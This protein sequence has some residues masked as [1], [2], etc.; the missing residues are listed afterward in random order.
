MRAVATC[1]SMI[2]ELRLLRQQR[3]HRALPRAAATP[4]RPIRLVLSALRRR[5]ARVRTVAHQPRRRPAQPALSATSAARSS[6]ISPPRSPIPPT[7]SDRAR[8]SRPT[9]SAAPSSWT[10]IARARSTGSRESGPTSVVQVKG[11]L[12]EVMTMSKQ[13]FSVAEDEPR[14]AASWCPAAAAPDEVP[15]HA[16][17]RPIPRISIQA[18]CED[19]AT[20][21]VVQAATA[22]RRLAKSHV[23]VHMGGA[24]AA[25]AHYHES[26]TPNLIIVET[27]A[28][29]RAD[30]G[31]A[32]PARRVLR[33]RHQG[34][35]DR[36]YQR[37]RALP[38]AAEA[39]RERVSDRARSTPLQLIESLSNLYNNPDTDPVGNVI[40]FIGAKG[41]VG[42]STVCHNTAWAMSEILKSNVVV[43]DLDLAFG[44]T[45]LDFNQDPVQGIA[46]ALQSP[47]RLDEVLLD[48]LLTKCSEQLSIFAAPGG[49]RPRLRDLGRRLRHRARRRAPE[50]A[51]RRRRSAAHL[52]AVGQARAAAGRRDRHHRRARPRQ[53]AQRQEPHRPAEAEPHQRRAA[54][55][56]HQHGQD[57]EAA[58]DLGQGVLGRARHRADAGDRVRRRDLRPGLQQRPDDRGVRRQGEGRPAVPRAGADPGAPQGAEGGEEVLAA[59]LRS[60]RSSSSSAEELASM[61]GRRTTT[62][63]SDPAP[64]ALR[65]RRRRGAGQGRR[66]PRRR[67][68]R[69]P[70]AR[71]AGAGGA[72]AAAFGRVLRRQ[73]D[74]LQRADRHHRP[75][76]A[77]QA[78]GGGG[79]R[80]DPRHRQRDHP[81]QERRDVDRR[82]GGAARGHLQRRAG[83]RPA[84]AAA[85][86]RR[87]RRHH[88]QRRQHHLHRGRR[89]GAE[90]A[91]CALPTTRS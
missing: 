75:D 79:A 83:L 72:G 82:A 23:S 51:L 68:S 45:G 53:P 35:R 73:D 81:D 90:D 13:A 76:P 56:R 43:A 28:A 86:P 48:R 9:R 17:A 87:H 57:A 42:S 41:G 26:P 46:E 14:P 71:Q 38:R 61:F 39:R 44:T 65:P 4:T 8:W 19:A 1:G 47:E 64:G 6:T 85:G 30:A 21:E 58:R 67:R 33:C 88:G 77:R 74:G 60:S 49:A 59:R 24:P 63:I 50:R 78:G 36:P 69:P 32:R 54:A 20:A 66:E 25:V 10:N 37:R 5:G 22:D 3:R 29:A 52:D 70:R 18:F 16:K 62:D 15:A 55:P 7:C 91:R 89:Q 80:G 12:T 84:R 40:A 2:S 31:R 34:G 11:E 27:S